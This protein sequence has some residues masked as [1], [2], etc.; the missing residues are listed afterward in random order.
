MNKIAIHA[1]ARVLGRIDADHAAAAE[2]DAGFDAGEWSGRWHDALAEKHAEEAL[3]AIARRFGMEPAELERQHRAWC[4]HSAAGPD[5]LG[6]WH[7]R[8]L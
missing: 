2:A 8:N 5:P 3:A 1:V 4:E 7:G 6:D